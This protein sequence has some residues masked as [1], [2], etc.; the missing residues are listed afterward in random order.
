MSQNYQWRSSW[1][2]IMSEPWQC[3]YV[4]CTRRATMHPPRWLSVWLQAADRQIQA[5]ASRSSLMGNL[6]GNGTRVENESNPNV[7]MMHTGSLL[8]NS[9][10]VCT[11]TWRGGWCA[12]IMLSGVHPPL[13]LSLRLS[14]IILFFSSDHNHLP[15]ITSDLKM[16]P[17]MPLCLRALPLCVA[18]MRLISL[19][20]LLT[21]LSMILDR[22]ITTLINANH[23]WWCG[24]VCVNAYIFMWLAAGLCNQDVNVVPAQWA[25]PCNYMS[26]PQRVTLGSQ[27]LWLCVKVSIKQR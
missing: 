11:Q 15:L 24:V 1:I 16:Y 20:I 12:F 9:A 8:A 6:F 21:I 2:F 27:W 25:L 5:S 19:L 22:V 3:H 10:D 14:P 23:L 4:L 17:I 18:G 26:T 13:L 7:K